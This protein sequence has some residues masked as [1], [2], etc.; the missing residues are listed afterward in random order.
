MA[1]E[2]KQLTE[3]DK[4]EIIQILDV[5]T[6]PRTVKQIRGKLKLTGRNLPEYLITRALRSL[7]SDDKVRFKGGRWMSNEI[8]E[9][10]K[11]PQTGYTPNIVD[12]PELSDA[13][14]KAISSSITSKPVLDESSGTESSSNISSG[15]WGQFRN[16]IHPD[17]YCRILVCCLSDNSYF[18]FNYN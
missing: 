15:P 6:Y 4:D 10:I 18:S 17:R 5:Q 14:G 2:L 7:Q 13:G 3:F 16:L 9:N 1:N 8:Y 11:V 12:F